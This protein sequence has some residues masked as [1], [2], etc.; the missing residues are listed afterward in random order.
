MLIQKLHSI[1]ESLQYLGPE[2]ILAVFFVLIIIFDLL[3][4]EKSPA[5]TPWIALSGLLITLYTVCIQSLEGVMLSGGLYIGKVLIFKY[6]FL[7]AGILTVLLS[8]ISPGFN[9]TKKGRGEYYAILIAIVLGLHIMSMASN[10][11]IMYLSIEL[12]SIGS[13]ILSVFSFDKR[14]AEA[15]LKYILYGAFSSGIMLFGFS[16]FY[17]LTGSL[18]FAYFFTQLEEAPSLLLLIA[19]MMAFGGLFFKI[20]AVP[21]HIWAPDVYEGAPIPVVSFFSIAPKAAGFALLFR[22]FGELYHGNI[23]S[24]N[25]ID[26]LMI[27]GIVIIASLTVGNFS[28]LLQNN[29]KRMLAYSSIAHAGFILIGL[30][31]L[32]Y[33]GLNSVLFYLC[34]Y[35]F[36]NFGAFIMVDILSDITGSEDVRNFKGLGLK[37]PFLGLIF[38]IILISL[39][40]LPPT[41]G[42]FAK[43]FVFSALWDAYQ[44]NGNQILIIVFVFGIL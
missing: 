17:A 13:Y 8:E 29:A 10:M 44:A 30:L 31:A 40:G 32:P 39:T 28:A 38:V 43:F 22:F 23:S 37:F 24:G 3:L 2:I 19:S 1:L 5:I 12:V 18:D 33:N 7:L 20:A 11:L 6:I 36:M 35:L 34:I 9:K 21:F 14:S 4:K 16:L 15:G 27:I 42:F 26:Y 25:H 41:A